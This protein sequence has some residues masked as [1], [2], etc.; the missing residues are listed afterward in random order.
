[1]TEKYRA[2]HWG[3][4]TK[5]LVKKD[6]CMKYNNARRLLYLEPDASVVLGAALLQVG[7]T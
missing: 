6:P 3:L 5:L 4:Y 2:P 7:T 1:M